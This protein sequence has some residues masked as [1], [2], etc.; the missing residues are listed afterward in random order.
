ML[1]VGEDRVVRDEFFDD[2]FTDGS[3]QNDQDD[4]LTTY[5]LINVTRD[6]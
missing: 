5:R 1:T 3:P 6:L 2:N 4:Y